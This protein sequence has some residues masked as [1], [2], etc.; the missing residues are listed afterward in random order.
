MA[1][2]PAFVSYMHLTALGKRG[3][4]LGEQPPPSILPNPIRLGQMKMTLTK[5]WKCSLRFVS[6]DYFLPLLSV[7]FIF[8]DNRIKDHHH[9]TKPWN[10]IRNIPSKSGRKPS[11]GMDR[12]WVPN[13]Q[14]GDTFRSRIVLSSLTW[15]SQNHFSRSNGT[16]NSFVQSHRV[17]LTSSE[18]WSW[19]GN[20]D[21][22]PKFILSVRDTVNLEPFVKQTQSRI[23]P[24][25]NIRGFV[26]DSG[27]NAR[28][29]IAK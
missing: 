2:F 3:F 10:S 15:E 4:H 27:I 26:L 1:Q 17:H 20:G 6:S 28:L 8:T 22:I 24:L 12:I 11:P 19:R 14:F 23:T 7:T 21:L 25:R 18:E 9:A 5:S 16:P 13:S 29:P